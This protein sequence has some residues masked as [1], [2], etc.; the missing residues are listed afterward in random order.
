MGNEEQNGWKI[1]KRISIGNLL[2]AVVLLCSAI[3]YANTFDKRIEQNRMANEFLDKT[4]TR[5]EARNTEFRFEVRENFKALNI[6]L[7]QVIDKRK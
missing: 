1:D 6:K 4:Q 3:T 7:D 2:T 5:T